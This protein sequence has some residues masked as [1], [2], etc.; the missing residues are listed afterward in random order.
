MAR[1]VLYRSSGV[2]WSVGAYVD[3]SGAPFRLRRA[4]EEDEGVAV[5]LRTEGVEVVECAEHR[6]A[7][8]CRSSC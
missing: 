2:D 3:A 6:E 8:P 4:R 5:L 1:V 7:K